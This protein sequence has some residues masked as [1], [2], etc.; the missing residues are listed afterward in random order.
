MTTTLVN[1]L[2]FD[3]MNEYGDGIIIISAIEINN[4]N[5]FTKG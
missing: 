4:L 3:G 1:H 2:N 5:Y